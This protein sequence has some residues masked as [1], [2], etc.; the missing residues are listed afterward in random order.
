M[1]AQLP[2]QF[3]CHHCHVHHPRQQGVRVQTRA[4]YRWRCRSSLQA[5]LAPVSERDAFGQRQTEF[6]RQHARYIN[7]RKRVP[8]SEL[9][10][11]V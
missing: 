5:A 8:L 6:N 2:E 4:G 7:L 10:F 3:Y 9:R 11:L 1:S